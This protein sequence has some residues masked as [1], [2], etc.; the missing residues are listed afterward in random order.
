MQIQKTTIVN[1]RKNDIDQQ[2]IDI[3]GITQRF[4]K[5]LEILIIKIWG[6]KCLRQEAKS[7]QN[8][9]LQNFSRK[10]L[11]IAFYITAN[12]INSSISPKNVGKIM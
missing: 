2:I 12:I 1:L 4:V 7:D 10:T 6:L 11:T 3:L 9:E 5:I 8:K